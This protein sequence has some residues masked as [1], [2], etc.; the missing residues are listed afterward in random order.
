[1]PPAIRDTVTAAP[2]RYRHTLQYAG[3]ARDILVQIPDGYVPGR[4]TPLVLALHAA[5]RSGEAFA[6]L[7]PDLLDEANRR[8]WLIAFP[9]GRPCLSGRGACWPARDDPHA[10]AL[11][12]GDDVGFLRTLVAD[13]QN[14]LAVDPARVYATGFSNGA[15]M[16]HRLAAEAPDLIAAAAPVAG[17]VGRTTGRTDYAYSMAPTP[18]A[19]VPMLIVKGLQDDVV[20]YHGGVRPS[21]TFQVLAA[22]YDANWWA[23]ANGCDISQVEKTGTTGIADRL[24]GPIA[25]HDYRVGCRAG[26]TVRLVAVAAMDHTWPGRAEG[27]DATHAVFGFFQ[28]HE[29]R[30][31]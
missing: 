30:S 4:P 11:A 15:N 7:H 1:M 12:A 8:G 9:D 3:A 10:V 18:T 25:T 21:G 22:E 31:R 26:A 5:G 29:R 23:E 20:V 2:G 13:L 19:P 17:F 6:R 24:D 14:R 16:T 28:R 27:Y